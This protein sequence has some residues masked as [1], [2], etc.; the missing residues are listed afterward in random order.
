MHRKMLR[1]TVGGFRILSILPAM[2]WAA[3]AMAAPV[4]DV[5]TVYLIP[6]DATANPSYEQAIAGALGDLQDWYADQLGGSTFAL[7]DPVVESFVTPHPSAFYATN[8]NGEP[9]LW[10]WNNVISDAFSLTGAHF[11]DP[12]HAWI[13]YIDAE[14]APG[15][16]GGA[17]TTG[18]AVLPQHDLLGLIGAQPE[19]VSRWVGGL[20]HEL[21]HAFGLPHPESCD[22]GLPSCP[23][24]T[25]MYLGYLT[26]P[27]T[28]LLPDDKAHLLEGPYISPVTESVPEP[29]TVVLS[30]VGLLCLAVKRQASRIRTSKSSP[31]TRAGA[32]SAAATRSSS[33]WGAVRTDRAAAAHQ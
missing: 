7:H 27:D 30:A 15:Q 10:F 29:S 20:G 11:A 3:P 28:Y 19:P 14:P 1:R 12:A 31:S 22:Q 25:L 23:F 16:I 5:R 26:Y 32:S 9:F 33:R 17:G 8:P 2:L 24:D 21:G 6:S 18:V 4:A 13:F